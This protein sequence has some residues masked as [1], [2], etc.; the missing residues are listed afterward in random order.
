VL[1][2][3]MGGVCTGTSRGRHGKDGATRG[4]RREEGAEHAADASSSR[5]TIGVPFRPLEIRYF[6]GLGGKFFRSFAMPLSRFFCRFS[7]F[8]FGSIC[9]EASPRHTR[10][11]PAAS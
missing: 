1:G 3:L 8:A 6:F 2:A 4:G 9:F 10:D 5:Q 7:G 11:F